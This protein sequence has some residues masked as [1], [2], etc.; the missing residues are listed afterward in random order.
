[1][2]AIMYPRRD[3]ATHM[4]S[5]ETGPSLLQVQ[6]LIRLTIGSHHWICEQLQGH[7]TA[8]VW[9]RAISLALSQNPSRQSHTS[10]EKDRYQEPTAPEGHVTGDGA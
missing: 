2:A 3:P 7:W 6:L 1:M 8:K 10:P 9:W 5:E 4:S